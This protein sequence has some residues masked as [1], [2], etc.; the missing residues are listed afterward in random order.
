[1]VCE[2]RHATPR[3][4][5]TLSLSLSHPLPPLVL[6]LSLS[7]ARAIVHTHTHTHT[8]TI[9]PFADTYMSLDAIKEQANAWG[10]REWIAFSTN[11]PMIAIFLVL[12]ITYMLMAPIDAEPSSKKKKV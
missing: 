4:T 8:S 3:F 12:R 1:M 5:C 6:S 7:L 11:V 2:H 10:S 9:F